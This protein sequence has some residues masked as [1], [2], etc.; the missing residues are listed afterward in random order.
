[1]AEQLEPLVEST[2]AVQ[3]RLHDVADLLRGSATVSREVRIALAELLDELS[4]A[5]KAPNGSPAA[6]AH[7]A[8]SAAH[9]AETL[10]H[11]HDGGL[12]ATA[13]K[14]LGEA[15]LKAEA[16]APNAVGLARGVVD[17]LANIGI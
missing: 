16:H 3:T 6:V 12:V 14:R 8:E 4:A 7:L 11:Q 1:M 17:S 13:R 2:Q 5:V 15:I 9:L 10:H